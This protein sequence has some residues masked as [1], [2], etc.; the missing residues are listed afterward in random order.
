MMIES[1]NVDLVQK[2]SFCQT[3][4]T[5]STGLNVLS[6]FDGMSCGQIALN[7]AGIPYDKYY[8]S[9]IDKHAI[10]VTQ[11]NYPDT[12]QL[13]S[14]IDIK[15]TDLP[16]VDLLIGGSPCQGFSFAGKQLN[17][18][19]PRSKLFFEFVRLKNECN[20]T[21]FLLENVKMKKEY[22]DIIT[23]YLGVKPIEINS[24]LVSAQNRKR[25]YWTNIPGVTQ[26]ED[27][28]IMLKDIV[29]ENVDFKT[30]LYSRK[31][32]LG[33]EIDKSTALCASDFRGLNRNQNQTSVVVEL[34]EY[35]VPFDKTLLILDKEIENG[36]VGYFKT[37]SQG[38][39]VYYIHGKA[40]TLCGNA[41]GKG[42]KTG[43]YLFGCI[44]PDRVNKRQNGQ[45]F[46][47]ANKFYTLTAQDRHGVLV[48][49]YIRRLTPIECER[50]QTL[51]DNYTAIGVIDGKEV[52]ISNT[53][54]YKMLGNGWTV[55][56][57]A[58][59]FGGLS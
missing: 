24:A 53:Q 36:K 22:E 26:P 39:R 13:G 23:E 31:T 50:L 41:G 6:L 17:F 9:E 44:T 47:D 5:G 10:K 45:R 12:I 54:R 27:K 57:I 59:I 21:Y 3:P 4:V 19:D 25:L 7:R 33:K 49:G 20:P 52:P 32:G 16:Q 35:I 28:G 11:H 55:D 2:P 18:D 58:H 56:V 1:T 30:C 34:A 14:V 29:H 51:P 15:G 43:L 8:A 37:D 40:V 46:N 42:A 38:N 48:E